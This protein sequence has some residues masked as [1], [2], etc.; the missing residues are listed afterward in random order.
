MRCG[1]GWE[2]LGYAPIIGIF[3]GRGG[4]GGLIGVWWWVGLGGMGGV[5]VMTFGRGER[6]LQDCGGQVVV[7]VCV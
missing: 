1:E 2:D 4:A 7:C 5:V 3:V 6:L